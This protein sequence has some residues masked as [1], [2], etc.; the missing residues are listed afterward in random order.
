MKSTVIAQ[1]EVQDVLKGF[2]FAELY[3]DATPWKEANKK[4]LR[5]RFGSA[6]LPLYVTVGP[7]GKERSRIAGLNSTAAFLDFLKKGLNGETSAA[8]ED[9]PSALAE[10]RAGEKPVF[11]EFHDVTSLNSLHMRERVLK[12]APVSDRLK[13]F[14]IADLPIDHGAR[15]KENLRVLNERFRTL[16]MPTYAVLGPDGGTRA[17]LSGTHSEA[18]VVA[19]LEKGLGR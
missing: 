9:L 15:A 16:A 8:H 2:V 17:V 1:K 18:D 11:V 10:A 19:F 12:R 14:V 6:A 13:G 4:L 3:T 7:D 5:E